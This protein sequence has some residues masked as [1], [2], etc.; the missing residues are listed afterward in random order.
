[1]KCI[2]IQCGSSCMLAYPGCGRKLKEHAVFG[3]DNFRLYFY[4][5]CILAYFYTLDLTECYFFILF[6]FVWFVF[7]VVVVAFF[8]ILRAFRSGVP[9][10]L[11]CI[12]MLSLFPPGRFILSQKTEWK[13]D[14]TFSCIMLKCFSPFPSFSLPWL[15]RSRT[16]ILSQKYKK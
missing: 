16:L 12:K 9:T 2:M 7:V 15:Y 4:F 13:N 5:L 1:M 11:S 6:L 10:L 8:S 14:C 3:Q